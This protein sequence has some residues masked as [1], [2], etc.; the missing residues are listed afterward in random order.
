MGSATAMPGTGL[1]RRKWKAAHL[2]S[3]V[4]GLIAVLVA[5]V[6]SGPTLFAGDE[7]GKK[8]DSKAVALGRTLFEREWQPGD[9]RTH[10]GDGLGPVYND[11]SC[12]ACHNQGGT[13]GAGSNGKNVDIITATPNMPGPDVEPVQAN[14]PR[15]FL[16]KALRSLIGLDKP[17]A[18]PA[19]GKPGSGSAKPARPKVDTTE[20]VK[21]HPG[22]RTARSVVL[23]HFSSDPAYEQWRRGFV[24]FPGVQIP[25]G[26]VGADNAVMFTQVAM[27]M[28]NTIAI[29]NQIGPFAISRSQRNP[30][31]LFGAGLIDSITEA[32][33][34]AAAKVKHAGFAE[35]A[36]RVSRLKDKRIGRFGWKAQTP[37]LDDFVLTACAVEL[38]LEVPAHHQGGLPANPE[39]KPKG[40]DLN[41]EECASLVAYVGNLP[42]PAQRK[43]ETDREA[44]EVEAGRSI[45]AKAG[46]ATCHA[47]KLGEVDGLYSD[48]LLHDLGPALGDVGQYGVFDPSSSEEEVVD[49]PASVVDGT[50]PMGPMQGVAGVAQM[51]PTAVSVEV[52]P[53]AAVT[54]TL[55]PAPRAPSSVVVS[56]P[57]APVADTPVAVAIAPN[58]TTVIVQRS[59]FD[60]PFSGGM[61]QQLP[62]VKRPTSGPASR[63]EWRTPPLW[64]FRDSAPY[65]HDGR[66][67]TLEQAVAMHGG[68]SARISQRFFKLSAKGRQQIET[69]LK[70]LS[71]PAPEELVASNGK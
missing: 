38:G 26:A 40:L 43:P 55:P 63:F 12:V 6:A 46:C 65:L 54:H 13:G 34:E 5:S 9:S 42:R 24:G 64:G 8:P 69:F 7:P 41:A 60:T 47:P 10:G 32:Q 1:L 68:E 44:N 61:A 23:H 57:P 58:P 50:M 70:S 15:G 28:E 4:A 53:E 45:F 71:A 18:P 3:I 25:Q 48:L 66:A 36:G 29:Q 21:A 30:T 56:A 62:A 49:D 11:S 2:G 33:I 20:L 52:T 31:A 51:D 17:A 59:P 27:G 39:A 22:F 37:S 14:G 35:I 16:E 19:P 67:K